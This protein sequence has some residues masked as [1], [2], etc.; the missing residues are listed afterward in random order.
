MEIEAKFRVDNVHA[1]NNLLSLDH[2]GTYTL[3]PHA[4]S[5]QQY[6]TYYD[7][8]DK[9]LQAAYYGLR[10]RNVEGQSIVTL[11]GPNQAKDGLHQRPEWEI[12]ANEPV[13]TS[14]SASDLRDHVIAL[15]GDAPLVPIVAIETTRH[16]IAVYRDNDNSEIAELCLDSGVFRAGE[17]TQEFCELEIELLGAGQMD[18]LH[19]LVEALHSHIHLIPE[20]RSKLEQALALLEDHL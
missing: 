7:T 11:K 6:N 9:R 19:A 2:I 8:H 13:P 17:R 12:E 15:I 16:L 4:H 1:M 10:I 5:T 14:W 3:Q 20:N 18:D